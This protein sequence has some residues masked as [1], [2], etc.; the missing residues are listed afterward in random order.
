MPCSA[1][2]V[3]RLACD[4]W[5]SVDYGAF[6]VWAWGTIPARGGRS[7]HGVAGMARPAGLGLSA[8]PATG[9]R[10]WSGCKDLH[11]EYGGGRVATDEQY[12]DW[13]DRGRKLG[14]ATARGDRRV[15]HLPGG[16]RRTRS[17]LPVLRSLRLGLCR[18][19]LPPF[20]DS[21]QVDGGLVANGQFV[22][23]ASD[24][25]LGPGPGRAE[26]P[27]LGQ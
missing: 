13:I 18:S 26:L 6:P 2:E 10:A 19:R 11:S 20:V 14:P 23:A 27:Q 17:R 21:G 1:G 3:A 4:A 15:G 24:P 12:R 22:E 7:C 25:R 8:E 16:S 9:L 5:T